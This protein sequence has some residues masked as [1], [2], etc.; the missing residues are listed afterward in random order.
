MVLFSPCFPWSFGLWLGHLGTGSINLSPFSDLN[1]ITCQGACLPHFDELIYRV[2][3]GVV[4][5]CQKGASLEDFLRDL[6][7]IVF[8]RCEPA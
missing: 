5:G 4:S 6:R 7:G 2:L 1:P 3:H 8:P